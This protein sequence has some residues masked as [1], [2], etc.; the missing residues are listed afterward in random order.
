MTTTMD[1][2]RFLASSA[3]LA[4]AAAATSLSPFTAAGAQ[5]R[6]RRPNLVFTS[7]CR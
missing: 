2:R 3:T 1:R 4:A 5:S 7:A 6:P